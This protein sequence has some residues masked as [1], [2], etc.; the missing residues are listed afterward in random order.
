MWRI[1][2]LAVLMCTVSSAGVSAV[3]ETEMLAAFWNL[4]NFFDCIDGGNGVSDMEFSA[5]G[6]R[7][8]TESR[9]WKK[10]HGV[11]KT[12]MWMA[13]RYG[14]VPDVVGV[15]EVENR[16]VMQ[17]VIRGTLLKKYD[18]VQ[19]HAESPDTRGIDVALI[20]RKDMFRHV[21]GR[22]ISVTRDMDGNAMKTRDILH[23]C[24][25]KEDGRRYHFLVN[26]HPS[27]YGGENETSGR[28]MA[29]MQVMVSVCDS[30][31]A[32]GE[33]DII[34]MGDF[35]DSPDGQAF[36]L[37]SGK[38]ENKALPLYR[39]GRGTVRYSGKWDLIDMFMTGGEVTGRSVMDI[40]FPDFLGVKDN[41]HSG[42]K[43]LRTYVGPVYA[44]GISDHLPIVLI[45]KKP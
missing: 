36:G 38:L 3:T 20:Y 2:I 6:N 25:E 17:A 19:V 30:L 12:I 28:R 35:N 5:G 13:D 39:S 41:A 24:L 32:A 22:S 31:L 4:E 37:V 7:H 21:G 9:F 29:A 45:V 23:V 8:W 34:C 16:G 33:P 26:H 27:K 14:R 18:Y 44:G 15:A 1:L 40:C 10:C 42:M 43:P 11:A